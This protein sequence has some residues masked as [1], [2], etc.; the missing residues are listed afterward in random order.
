MTNLEKQ[1]YNQYLYALRTSQKQP[2][3]PRTDFKDFEQDPKYPY[4]QK[5]TTFFL[6]FPQIKTELYFKAPYEIYPDE[7]FFGL[8]FYTSRK[9]LNVYTIYMKERDKKSPDDEEQL[10]FIQDSFKFI[11]LFCLQNKIPFIEYINHKTGSTYTWMKHIKERKISIYS[12][13]EFSNLYNTITETPQDECTIFLGE[14]INKQFYAYKSRY[15]LSKYA[16]P[17]SQK[18]YEKLS[19]T[20][21]KK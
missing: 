20:V 12:L 11:A 4:L 14:D 9:A 10:N 6:K 3:R 1:Y 15:N 16:K 21:E 19:K 8:E 5:L 7:T 13:L 17:F 2:F 18:A